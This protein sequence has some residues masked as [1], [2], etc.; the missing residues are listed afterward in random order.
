MRPKGAIMLAKSLLDGTGPSTPSGNSQ[1]ARSVLAV[2]QAN[3]A[4]ELP[5]LAIASSA[6]VQS[7]QADHHTFDHH[8]HLL[9]R[10]R[11]SVYDAVGKRKDIEELEALRD[12][13]L[14]GGDEGAI[15]A[16]FRLG[17]HKDTA[18][19][20]KIALLGHNE[21]DPL[22]SDALQKRHDNDLAEK[23]MVDPRSVISRIDDALDRIGKLKDKLS[24]DE[25]NSY[26]Q[27]LAFSV[28][29]NSLNVARTQA[30]DSAYSVSAASAAVESI[31]TNLRTAVAA[32]GGASADMVRL[33]LAS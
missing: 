31:M 22:E 16:A 8:V 33:V 7:L 28:S 26:D 20:G 10:M 27:L 29:V 12:K 13:I 1:M 14:L 4:A 17:D 5:D 18:V 11:S 32:H 15:E 6:S 24:Q 9:G 3:S 21:K 25:I 2:T 19:I 23:K 30:S